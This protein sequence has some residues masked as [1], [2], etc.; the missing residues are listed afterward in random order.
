M[1]EYLKDLPVGKDILVSGADNID[2]VNKFTND[3]SL[4]TLED[5]KKNGINLY[6]SCSIQD[7]AKL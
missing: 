7:M 3:S 6:S 1:G 4:K 2:N 5:L